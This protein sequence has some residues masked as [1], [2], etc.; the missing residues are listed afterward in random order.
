MLRLR[1]LFMEGS[2]CQSRCRRSSILACPHIRKMS[3]CGEVGVGWGCRKPSKAP[4]TEGSMELKTSGNPGEHPINSFQSS[5]ND[6]PRACADVRIYRFQINK[7]CRD[8]SRD[9]RCYDGEFKVGSTLGGCWVRERN[10][11]VANLVARQGV[12]CFH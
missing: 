1:F 3:F 5:L 4:S 12:V 8:M 9:G 7:L 6:P 11:R 2:T 10:R